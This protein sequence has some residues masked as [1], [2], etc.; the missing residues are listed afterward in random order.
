M[1]KK[2]AQGKCKISTAGGPEEHVAPALSRAGGLEPAAGLALLLVLLPKQ[3]PALWEQGPE[4][5]RGMWAP[6]AAFKGAWVGKRRLCTNSYKAQCL[7][8]GRVT[9]LQACS[10]TTR[11]RSATG[12]AALNATTTQ[13]SDWLEPYPF[14]STRMF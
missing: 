2:I 13:N 3:A 10:P 5:K 6:P 1:K 4:N 14:M 8:K 7:F 11:T 9:V 12:S